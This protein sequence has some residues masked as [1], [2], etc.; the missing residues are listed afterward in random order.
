MMVSIDPYETEESIE[1]FNSRAGVAKPLPTV[2]D[3]GDVARRFGANGLETTVI[4]DRNGKEVFRDATITDAD[5]LRVE[6]E[7]AL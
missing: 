7:S 6:L 1:P 5:T 4:L 2:V 3:G